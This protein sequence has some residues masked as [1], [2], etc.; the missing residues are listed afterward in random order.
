MQNRY[1]RSLDIK[2]DETFFLWGLR[3]IGKTSYLKSQFPNAIYLDLLLSDEL[4]KYQSNPQVLREELLLIEQKDKP[5][6]IIDEIQ[7]VPQLLNEIH[8]LIENT[9]IKFG[10]CGSSARKVKRGAANLLGGRAIRYEMF[11]LNSHELGSDFELKR[12]L[13]NGYLP[14]A[15][16][17]SSPKRILNSYVTDYIKEEILEEG[18]LQNLPPFSDFLRVVA[19]SDTELVNYTNIASEVGQKQHHVKSY[20][21]ILVDTMLGSFLPSYTRK[22]KRRVIHAPKFYLSDLG[23]ANTLAKRGTIEIGSSLFGKAFENWIF[24]ELRSYNSYKERYA[25]FCYWKL[26]SGTEVDFIINDMEVAIEIKGSKN[27]TNRNLKGLREV[28]K[29]HPNIKKRIVVSLEQ[30]SRKTE[31]G[32]LILS[33]K[34]FISRLWNE[35]I[36]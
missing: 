18:L 3:Q 4:I 11:G 8:W 28:Y 19:I 24:H 12:I 7:K 27:I 2:K 34:E 22:N 32:I 10:L 15:Y 14:R 25:D 26:S 5:I 1:E 31:D 36:F 16:Q 17:S 9:N 13:N 21:E 30:K 23:I 29:D 35:E 6:V 20:Y 33:V